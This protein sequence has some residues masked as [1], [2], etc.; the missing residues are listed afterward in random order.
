VKW[1]KGGQSADATQ[2]LCGR[3]MTL[4][5]QEVNRPETWGNEKGST[6]DIAA[7]WPNR[8]G[9]GNHLPEHGIN[10]K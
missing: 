6:E 1:R 8:R 10:R 3:C 9:D 4:F 2:L 7:F 5:V